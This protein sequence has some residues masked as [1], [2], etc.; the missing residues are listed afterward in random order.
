MGIYII[1]EIVSRLTQPLT[2]FQLTIK[3][4]TIKIVSFKL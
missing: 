2:F 4:D 3:E 1:Q